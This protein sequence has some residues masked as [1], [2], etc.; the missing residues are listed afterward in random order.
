MTTSLKHGSVVVGV[1]GSPGSEAALA[2]AVRYATGRNKPLVILHSGGDPAFYTAYADPSETRRRMQ[3]EARRVAE[4]ALG[5]ARR[6]APHLEMEVAEPMLDARDALIESSTRAAIV[7]V[8]TR[9]RGPVRALL[10]GSVSTAVAEHASCPVAVVRPADRETS[11]EAHIVVGTDGGP[12]S[13]AALE[14]AF[15][16]AS[17]ERRA[18]DV[19]H[20]WSGHDIFIDAASYSQ[21]EQLMEEHERML[22]ESLAGYAEKYPDVTVFRHMPD[23]GAVQSLVEMSADAAAVV[24]GSRGRTGPKVLAG[25]VSRLVVER[26]HSTV[27]VVRP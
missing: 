5:N 11:S 16:L 21:S 22:G 2:W 27:V 19:V 14:F 1:D 26:A 4:H 12:A 9:G 25:S 10:L 18:L 24:I 15:E 6:L 8:G 17:T 7:V 3:T 20:S 23:G 13:T